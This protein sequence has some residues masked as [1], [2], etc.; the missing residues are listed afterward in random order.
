MNSFMVNE[1]R[2]LTEGFPAF[3]TFV[4]FSPRVETLMSKKTL[5]PTKGLA[6]LNTFIRL[7]PSVDSL[8]VSKISVGTGFPTLLTL[9]ELI[10]V[11]NKTFPLHAR[12]PTLGALGFVPSMGPLVIN[13]LEPL[14]ESFCT[15][16]TLTRLLPIR[17]ALGLSKMAAAAISLLTVTTFTRLSHRVCS[18]VSNALRHLPEGLLT[19]VTSIGFVSGVDS[20][21]PKFPTLIELLS[22]GFS[23]TLNRNGGQI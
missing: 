20:L 1:L 2:V 5:T 6:T 3:T 15:S 13:E 17:E 8:V 16:S 7:L 23:L 22:L 9:I 19:L 11:K 21:V 4:W 12:L 18:E 10:A 14:D